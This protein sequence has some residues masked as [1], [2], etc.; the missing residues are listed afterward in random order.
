MA[1]PLEPDSLLDDTIPQH[2]DMDM[3]MDL[4]QQ[5][6]SSSAAVARRDAQPEEDV[7]SPGRLDE[8]DFE[9]SLDA[10]TTTTTTTCP[11][12]P[13]VARDESSSASRGGGEDTTKPGEASEEEI[14][15][16]AQDDEVRLEIPF[17]ELRDKPVD[18]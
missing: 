16:D 13:P 14:A 17:Y 15:A 3:D 7:S 4:Q 1:P 5:H 12:P 8:F 6:Q 11:P 9:G 2:M 18:C 10:I